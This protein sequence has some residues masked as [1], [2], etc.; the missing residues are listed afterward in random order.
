[1]PS[2][3]SSKFCLGD[4]MNFD[5]IALEIFLQHK[6]AGITV[7]RLGCLC[8]SVS[9]LHATLKHSDLF[10]RHICPELAPWIWRGFFLPA[11]H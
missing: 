3:I 4:E 7:T 9:V 8:A 1:M 6:R 5:N 2:D 11:I 10:V